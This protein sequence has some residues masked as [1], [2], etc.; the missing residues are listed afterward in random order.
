MHYGNSFFVFP[1]CLKNNEDGASKRGNF[2]ET[3]I[4]YVHIA[5]C[6]PRLA[7]GKPIMFLA[8]DRV[9]KFTVVQFHDTLGEVL[10]RALAG[11]PRQRLKCSPF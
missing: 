6:E 9:S 4:G 11:G 10:P 1:G 2:A 7:K 3:K 5:S 8:I